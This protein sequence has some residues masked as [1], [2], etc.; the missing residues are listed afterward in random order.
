[1]VHQEYKPQGDAHPDHKSRNIL[2]RDQT[3]VFQREGRSATDKTVK[4][5]ESR[6]PGYGVSSFAYVVY[7]ALHC[8][9]LVRWTC[10]LFQRNSPKTRLV[11]NHSDR[12]LLFCQIRQERNVGRRQ[13]VPK[14]Q[15]ATRAKSPAPEFL[16]PY[17][18][19][20]PM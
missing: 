4:I 5:A 6:A 17:A 16:T 13:P 20:K 12:Y 8:K 7:Y 9:S 14:M 15:Q 1:M 10:C 11:C 3:N 18:K 19:L 2:S